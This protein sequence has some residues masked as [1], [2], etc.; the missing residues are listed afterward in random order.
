MTGLGTTTRRRCIFR[1]SD[2]LCPDR[3]QVLNQLTPE[4][5]VSGEVLFMSDRG[6]QPDRFAIVSVEG[7]LSPLIVPTE[8]LRASG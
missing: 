4:L 5:E 2:V 8:N 7:I 1:L 6:E 3:T